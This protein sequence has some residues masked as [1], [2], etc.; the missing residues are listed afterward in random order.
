M[1][2]RELSPAY[3]AAWRGKRLRLRSATHTRLDWSK[4]EFALSLGLTKDGRLI[5]TV[6]ITKGC[7]D[8]TVYRNGS[9]APFAESRYEV[10]V[11][12][13]HLKWPRRKIRPVRLPGGG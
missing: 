9:Y 13:P 7:P 5:N 1:R 2:P 4:T 11:E 10:I 8:S 12:L 3:A 6:I